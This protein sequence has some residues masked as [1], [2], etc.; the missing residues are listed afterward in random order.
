MHVYDEEGPTEVRHTPEVTDML[1]YRFGFSYPGMEFHEVEVA[2][3]RYAALRKTLCDSDCHLSK[4]IRGAVV[5]FVD[6]LA[7]RKAIPGIP[8]SLWDL[9]ESHESPLRAHPNPNLII[10]PA[11]I[12]NRTF[13]FISSVDSASSQNWELATEH[14]ATA[15]QCRRQ[16]WGPSILDVV[17]HLLELGIPFRTWTPF[18]PPQRPP[19]PHPSVGLGWRNVDY[20]PDAADYAS[21]AAARD[22]FLIRSLHGRAALLRGGIAWRLAIEALGMA[23]ALSGPSTDVYDHGQF[24]IP[25]TGTQFWDDALTEEELDLICGVYK[26]YTG[27]I[28][29]VCD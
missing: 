26:V 8:S 7:T 12:N 25:Q 10:R 13:Y 18:T 9:H 17:Q 20:K 19:Y 16:E 28:L 21:Y 14:A 23:P 6:N 11:V 2:D 24:I 22:E 29:C 3:Q 4:S 27:R 5:S 1:Y 15:M